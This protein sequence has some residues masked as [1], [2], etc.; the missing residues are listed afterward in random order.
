MGHS[1]WCPVKLKAGCACVQGMPDD[2]ID[3]PGTVHELTCFL[4]YPSGAEQQSVGK[5]NASSRPWGKLDSHWQP[6]SQA[7]DCGRSSVVEAC[8]VDAQYVSTWPQSPRNG[9]RSDPETTCTYSRDAGS[10]TLIE[11]RCHS[12]LPEN[13]WNDR[14]TCK[15]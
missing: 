6:R 2:Q 15:K 5:L 14:T 9:Q 7:E 12:L 11:P 13:L 10:P 3:G 8:R 1:E 4:E